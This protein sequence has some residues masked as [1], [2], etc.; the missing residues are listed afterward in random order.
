MEEL[1]FDFIKQMF[2]LKD[3]TIIVTGGAGA[4]GEAVA[5]GC[6]VHGAD[7]VVTGRTLKTLE[8]AVKSVEKTG[9]KALALVCDVTKEDEVINMV[10]K[11]KDAFGKI[12]AVVTVA[13]IAK[14][15]PAEEFPIGDWEQVMDINVKGTF[16][17]LQ[18]RG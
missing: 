4:L 17:N 7:I 16:L 8:K 11:T 14:R 5:A 3:K 15:Y 2:S 1:N 12:D 9:R 6:A 10:K 18:T 13:G